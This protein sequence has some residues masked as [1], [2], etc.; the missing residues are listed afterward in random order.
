MLK[1]TV[2]LSS[3]NSDLQGQGVPCYFHDVKSSAFT[4]YSFQKEYGPHRD[5]LR[6]CYLTLPRENTSL[7]NTIINKSDLVSVDSYPIYFTIFTTSTFHSFAKMPL[8][9]YLAW[10]ELWI[11]TGLNKL[12]KQKQNS[13]INGVLSIAFTEWIFRTMSP[14]F[15]V[16]FHL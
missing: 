10:V 13:L 7:N 2:F 16:F 6:K 4:S 3:T 11:F 15:Q 12:K 9:N 14:S 1:Q 5:L 8:G